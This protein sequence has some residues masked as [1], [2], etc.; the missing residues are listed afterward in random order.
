MPKSLARVE[1]RGLERDEE[2][3]DK[4]VG[5]NSELFSNSSSSPTPLECQKSPSPH[6][7]LKNYL[8]AAPERPTTDPASYSMPT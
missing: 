3:Q 8:P 5:K 4:A 7:T 2:L 6:P 1:E